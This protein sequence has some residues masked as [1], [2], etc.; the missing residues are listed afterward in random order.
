MTYKGDKA[1]IIALRSELA[2]LR[3]RYDDGA[4]PIAVYKVIRD[5]ETSIAWAKHEHHEPRQ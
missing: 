2:R 5:L 4:V 1:G 3:A